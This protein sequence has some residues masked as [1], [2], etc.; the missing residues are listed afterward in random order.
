MY[1]QDCLC[2]ANLNHPLEHLAKITFK[3]SRQDIYIDG[4]SRRKK[5]ETWKNWGESCGLDIC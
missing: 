4:N 2:A 5:W 3:S 1:I